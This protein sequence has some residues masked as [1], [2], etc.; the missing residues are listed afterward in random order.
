[1]ISFEEACR[2]IL[3][4][5][6]PL[7]RTRV[8][9]SD[10]AGYVLAA[11]VITRYHI[12]RFDSSAVDGY[13][14]HWQDVTS[15]SESSPVSLRLAGAVRAGDVSKK[16]IPRGSCVKLMT[17]AM[18][19][20][21]VNAVIMREYTEE[22]NH[23][24]T[25]SSPA[26]RGDNVRLNGEEFAKGAVVLGEGARITPTA[27][28]LLATVGCS[29][30]RVHRKPR[31]ALIVTGNELVAADKSLKEG[32]IRDSNSPALVAAL[33]RIGVK[34][35]MVA[36]TVDSRAAIARALNSALKVSDVVITVGG[37]SVGDFDYVKGVA[38]RYGIKT[39]FW[40]VAIKPGKPFFFGTKG[41]KLVFGLPGNP[42]S[43]LITFHLFVVPALHRMMGGKLKEELLLRA[44]LDHSL[45]RN[46]HRMEFVRGLVRRRAS[47][48]LVV[49]STR[50]QGSHML[51]GLAAANCIIYVR[52]GRGLLPKRS[53]VDVQM[54]LWNM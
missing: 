7:P 45:S 17:G 15:A 9:L 39:A 25:V 21:G 40:R 29:T 27:V 50:G 5:T 30:V 6:M 2:R 43:A 42:V 52:P 37:V 10:A 41:R 47:D 4:K 33:Q 8:R 12:P 36:R 54:L 49:S 48:G 53:F 23:A 24:V 18:V 13:G 20:R 38:E 28:G 44:R 1:M 32:K 22:V 11:P 51:G 31:V 26:K 46:P 19:P 3:R 35:G 14:V 16:T 34:P